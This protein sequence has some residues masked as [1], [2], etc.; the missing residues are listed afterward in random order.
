MV[1]PDMFPK[2]IVSVNVRPT[3][4][5]HYNGCEERP[6]NWLW[7]LIGRL[8]NDSDRRQAFVT[9]VCEINDMYQ[10]WI[11]KLKWDDTGSRK[12]E[13]PFDLREYRMT[14][15]T[16]KFNVIS[17]IH[18]HA[19]DDKL[20]GH[21]IVCRLVSEEREFISDMTLNTMAHFSTPTY[22]SVGKE[23]YLFNIINKI[24]T[25]INSKYFKYCS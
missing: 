20:V 24:S 3:E 11:R 12:C 10:P 15:E 21:P 23:T 8:D 5:K 16:W 14:D 7:R 6:K 2:A 25:K 18:N 13:C 19:F 1:H 17:D 22:F 4:M 9:M